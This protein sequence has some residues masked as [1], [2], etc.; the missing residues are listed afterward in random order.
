MLRTL[1]LLTLAIPALADESFLPETSTFQGTA[2]RIPMRDGKSLAA[3]FYVPKGGGKLPVVLIQTPYDR[4]LMRRHW[5]GGI[6]D[7]KSPLFLDTNY[8]FVITDWRGRHDSKD[9]LAGQPANLSN[10][11]FDTIAWVVAQQWSNGKVGT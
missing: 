3:D 4:K 9:A 2:T 10:D 8:A 7:G 1:F 5:T 6:D 11:G